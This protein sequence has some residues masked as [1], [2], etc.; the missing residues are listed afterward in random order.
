MTSYRFIS[1]TT[2]MCAT[3]IKQELKAH[4]CIH[5]PQA[6]EFLTNIKL[7]D[8][9]TKSLA[10]IQKEALHINA[11]GKHAFLKKPTS[12]KSSKSLI[13]NSKTISFSE[14]NVCGNGFLAFSW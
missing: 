10:H 8:L 4:I 3:Q 9:F 14:L 6:L 7:N 1:E 2:G 13:I 11:A 5:Y 12:P